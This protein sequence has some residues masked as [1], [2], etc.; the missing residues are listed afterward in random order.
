MKNIDHK[1]TLKWALNKAYR[2]LCEIVIEEG[3]SGAH[4]WH[5]GFHLHIAGEETLV[6]ILARE[7]IFP[8]SLLF[9]FLVFLRR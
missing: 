9:L 8:S 5:T 4:W 1:I 2:N 6:Q 3:V 7:K